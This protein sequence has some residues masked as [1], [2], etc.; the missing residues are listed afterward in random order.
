MHAE[1]TSTFR[2]GLLSEDLQEGSRPCRGRLTELSLTE[3][4]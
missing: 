4:Y 2:D 3:G 1:R